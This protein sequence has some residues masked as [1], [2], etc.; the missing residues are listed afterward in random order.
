MTRPPARA[1]AP[2]P[3]WLWNGRL[4]PEPAVTVS[5][6]D[7]GLRYGDGLYET[8]RVHR[9]R[10]IRLAEHLARMAQGL[11]LLALALDPHTAFAAATLAELVAQNGLA[12]GEGRLR[13]LVTRGIDQ[14]SARPRPQ[15]SRPGSPTSSPFRRGPRSDP[16]PLR[17]ATVEA[18]APRPRPGQA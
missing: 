7:R 18:A 16:R 10:V 1:A 2:A 9:G 15:R 17:L 11:A 5:P 13:L 12:A 3:V 4:V 6:R 8:L 14:G